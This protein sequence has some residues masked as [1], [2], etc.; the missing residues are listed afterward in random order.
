MSDFAIQTQGLCKRFG[1]VTAVDGLDLTVRRG[2]IFGLVGPDG[3]GK[4]T[5]L[6]LL[7]GILRPTAGRAEVAGFDVVAAPEEVKA[8]I[9]YLSQ[10]FSL[11]GDLTVWENIAFT[12]ELYRVPRREWEPR[13]E[14]L[15]RASRMGPFKRRL[16]DHLSG[17]MQQKL[18]LTCALIH[19][20]EVL[21]LDEP[22]TGVDPVSRREF[23]TILYGLPAQ[24]VTVVISTPYLDEAE[25]C[26]RLMF[27]Q[28]GR[29]LACD[30][31]AGL[32]G[33]LGGEVLALAARPGR[34]ARDVLRARPEVQQVNLLGD[35]LHVV[36]ENAARD[37]PGLIQAL[38][39]AGLE[40]AEPQAIPPGLEDVF[41]KLAG[42]TVTQD[43]LG[44]P[45]ELEPRA[46]PS[47]PG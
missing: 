32:K 22:T 33:R 24:G 41:V 34:A 2:E 26:M 15:L 46:Y 37:A 27:L 44:I 19:T 7:A 6:R 3:A 18:A 47:N 23:W 43:K 1:D 13:A 35:V 45:P 10:R 11:Y 17:G 5:T 39:E 29:S 31:P 38:R 16:A 14:E 40:T 21:L 36:V 9:G 30:T 12:A 42:E 25:R 4:T 20:P 28:Q 8:R